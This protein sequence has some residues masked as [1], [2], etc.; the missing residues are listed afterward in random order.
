MAN[1]DRMEA[2]NHIVIVAVMSLSALGARF[3]LLDSHILG[4]LGNLIEKIPNEYVRKPLGTCERCMVSVWGTAAILALGFRPDWY[5]LP[6]YWL[7]ADG[8]QEMF[9]R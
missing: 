2:A 1:H 3:A 5:L 8:L 4:W 7:A 6:V 9:D